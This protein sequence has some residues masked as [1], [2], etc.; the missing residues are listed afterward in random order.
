M[1]PPG[2]D[3]VLLQPHGG[4]QNDDVGEGKAQGSPDPGGVEEALACE[5]P[6]PV[7]RDAEGLSDFSGGV[8]GLQVPSISKMISIS[9]VKLTGS[10]AIPTAER[11][12]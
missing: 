2:R 4:A 6:D 12:W 10:E 8:S 1:D 7:R 5:G 9:T 3:A 11:A